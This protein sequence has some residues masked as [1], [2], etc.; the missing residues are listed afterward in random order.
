VFN[1]DLAPIHA[2][3]EHIMSILDRHATLIEEQQTGMTANMLDIKSA[4]DS[5][6]QKF[7]TK[8]KTLDERVEPMFSIFW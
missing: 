2:K 1:A 3:L 4:V 5:A 7:R 6:L 8:I